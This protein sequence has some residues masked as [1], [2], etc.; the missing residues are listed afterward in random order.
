MNYL[1]DDIITFA[2]FMHYAVEHEKKLEIIF[3]DLDTNKNG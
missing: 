2:E 3:R 1:N